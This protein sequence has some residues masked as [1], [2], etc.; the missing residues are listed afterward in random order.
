MQ[1]GEICGLV[2]PDGAG[3]TTTIRMLGGVISP[4]AGEARV[5]GF[6]VVRQPEAVKARLGYVA[7]HFSLYEDLTVAENLR[8]FADLYGVPRQLRAEREERL[9]RFSR[10]TPFR[11]RLA[12]HL[13]GGMRQKLALATALVHDPVVLLLDEPTTGV[14]P[15]SRREFWQILNSLRARGVAMVYSTPYMDEAE[16]CDRVAFLASGRLLALGTTD[17]LRALLPGYVLAVE[18]DE[19][20]RW[21]RHLAGLD[22]VEDVQAFGDKLHVLVAGVA[23]EAAV[24]RVLAGAG[25]PSAPERV[26]PSLE[27][28]FMYLRRH[29]QAVRRPSDGSQR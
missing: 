10:L 4:T 11:D 29:E 2:G 12:Q 14:D 8:F 23:E 25:A 9:L 22:C 26:A 27:D 17:E 19:P 21:Q 3:K 16:R 18:S 13:S 5:A 1:P 15:V 28:V 7:Q 6:D 20:R 24:A